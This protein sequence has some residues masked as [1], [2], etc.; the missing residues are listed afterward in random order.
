VQNCPCPSSNFAS[1]RPS[2]VKTAE[3]SKEPKYDIAD[4]DPAAMIEA[5]RAFGYDLPRAISDLVDNSI[6]AEAENIWVDFFW[7]GPASTI[8][9]TD[10]GHGMTEA[11]LVNAMRP[12]SQNP[13]DARDP[14]DLGR[15]GLGLKTASF[16]QCRRLSVR[17]RVAR[18]PISTRCWDLDFVAHKREWALLH[19]AGPSAKPHFKRLSENSQGTA[20][21]WQEMDRLVTGTN[22]ND[23]TQRRHFHDRIASVETHLSMVFHRFL[24]PKR[25]T[26]YVNNQK[27]EPWDPFLTSES[28]TQEIADQRLKLLQGQI[29]IVPYVLPHVNKIS[30]EKHRRA[31]GIKGWNAHQGF[32]V[33]RNERL[34]VAGDWLGLGFTKEEH[35][36]L[37]RIL[38]DIPNSMDHEWDIDV[39][40]SRAVPPDSLR[41]E[42]KYI[43]DIT[44]RRASDIFRHRGKV[45]ARRTS[46]EFVF[47]WQQIQRRGKYLYRVNREHPLVQHALKE[48][49]GVVEPLLRLIEETVPIPLLTITNSEHPDTHAAPFEFASSREIYSLLSDVYSAIRSANV[50]Q[51]KALECIAVMEPFERYPELVQ[52]FIEQLSSR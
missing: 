13:L 1:F 11:C 3:I 7:D 25:L 20:I 33:Y 49:R 35:F 5:L 14:S 18:G 42:F 6:F 21:L 19:N 31:A 34:L 30:S 48:N 50:T 24:R 26:I 32:Y 51:S 40:K 43:A 16:S 28:A 17:T 9:V 29:R 38:V 46:Q 23:P 45:I 39:T 4:P 37:A 44:R 22:V 36:K 15:F 52:T 10:D 41:P 2:F 27:I 47:V 12:G 8:C